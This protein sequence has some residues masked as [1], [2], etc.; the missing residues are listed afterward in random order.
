MPRQLAD[1]EADFLKLL[2]ARETVNSGA[3][4]GDGDGVIR[5]NVG[6]YDRIGVEIKATDAKSF[7]LKKETWDKIDTEASRIGYMPLMGIDI[8]GTKLIVMTAND[9]MMMLGYIDKLNDV[10]SEYAG[11]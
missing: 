9:F 10:I 5:H 4:F 7:S 1:R 6:D 8:S 3:T 2:G 11:R